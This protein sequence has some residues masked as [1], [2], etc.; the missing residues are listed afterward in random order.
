[1]PDMSPDNITGIT[2]GPTTAIAATA[3]VALNNPESKPMRSP[4]LKDQFCC[5]FLS[6]FPEVLLLVCSRS[7]SQLRKLG[8]IRKG[9]LGSFSRRSYSL[10]VLG[11]YWHFKEVEF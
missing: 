6:F 4:P 8:Y 3:T 7:K 1:M 11:D 9:G 5:I 2:S 10:L